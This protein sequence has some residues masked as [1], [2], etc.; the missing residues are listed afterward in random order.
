MI[1]MNMKYPLQQLK[2]YA[3]LIRLNRPIGICLLLWPTLWALW[4]ASAGRP[5]PLLVII[6]IL[7]VIVMRS[8]GVVINDF[9]DRNI[10]RH[11]ARTRDRPLTSGKVSSR[12]AWVLFICLMLIALGLVAMLNHYTVKL[13]LIGAMLAMVYPFT[14]RYLHFPQLFLGLAYAWGVPMA[15]AAVLGYV[16]LSGW[17][18]YVAALLWPIAYD[19]MYAMVDRSDDIKIGVKSTAILFGEFDRPI[20]AIIQLVFLSI[21][22]LVGIIDKLS[23]SYYLACVVALGLM[24][25]QQ[26][27]L[28]QANTALYFK[29]FLN[30]HWLGLII[31]AG[32]ALSYY[33]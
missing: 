18:L 25:Y 29:A 28:S 30:N 2:N 20:I 6:F 7:G 17:I 24:V 1:N 19:T 22:I 14:K 13:A 15:F 33:N 32:L 10:D 23:P 26:I 31:F 12:E 21:L 5:R 27:L 3:V 4:L 11:V 9:A 16:P 8:A